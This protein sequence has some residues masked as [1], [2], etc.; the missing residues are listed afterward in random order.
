[1]IITT[2]EKTS[3]LLENQARDIARKYQLPFIKRRKQSVK[4]LFK[5]YESDVYVVGVKKHVLNLID[6]NQKIQFHPN[7]AKVRSKRLISGKKDR[8][9]QFAGIK[10][11]TKVLDCTMG[12][13]SDSV[14]MSLAS[15]ESGRVT[16][17]ESDFNMY[18]VVSE[19]LKY[20]DAEE[21]CINLAMRR[22]HPVN[23]DYKQVLKTLDD[24]SVDVVYF[25]P[26]FTESIEN[27]DGIEGIK[28]LVNFEELSKE[29]VDEAVRVACDK[30]IIKDHFR[31]ISFERLGFKRDTRPSS[32][33]H[34]GIIYT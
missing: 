34:Y 25:D 31:S 14:V 8:L 2:A 33:I 15:G 10:E 26:M 3:S 22:I 21:D 1:M 20:Y 23:A 7:L 12:L 32:R 27:S 28:S 5:I 30:V 24:N 6:T 11:G 29:S 19:G 9:I 13:G 4:Q 18:M 17:V 16:A